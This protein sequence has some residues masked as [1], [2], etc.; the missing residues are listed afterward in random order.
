MSNWSTTVLNDAIDAH[1]GLD[2]W[3]RRTGVASTILTGGGLWDLKGVTLL[4]SPRRVTSEFRRQWTRETPFGEPEMAMTWTPK[5]VEITDKRG[6]VV[7]QRDDGR[8]SFDRTFNGLWDALN[9]AYFN[10]YAMWTYHATPW[11]LTEPGY[12]VRDIAPIANE[13]ETLKGISVRFPEGVHSHSR[14]QRFYF[15]TDGLLQRHD[16]EVDVWAD[17]P[18]AHF[19]SDYVDVDGLKYPTRRSVF[20]RR[21]DGTPDLDLNAVTISLSDYSLF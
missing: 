8:D 6:R 20:A 13:R 7:A 2:R 4:R 11:V 14:E 18:A 9:L 19:V 1:G 17:M 5:R 16:Y 3:R 10:G 15:G 21:P 12:E